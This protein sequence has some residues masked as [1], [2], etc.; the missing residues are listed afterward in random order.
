MQKNKLEKCYCVEGGQN[1][2]QEI[3]GFIML[4]FLDPDVEIFCLK[5]SR[6]VCLNG[7]HILVFQF[8]T[9][10]GFKNPCSAVHIHV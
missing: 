8:H 7:N 9:L 4:A 1:I 3:Y 2:Y 10:L 5:E 6:K